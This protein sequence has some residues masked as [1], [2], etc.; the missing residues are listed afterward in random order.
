MKKK[1]VLLMLCVLIAGCSS[2]LDRVRK[3]NRER[4][5]KLST[6]LT[7]EEALKVMGK[8]AGGGLFG[9]PTVKSPYKSET[10]QSGGRN[11]EILY[12]YTDINSR[13]HISNPGTIRDKD[14]TP[15][16]FE[17]DILI[18]WGN[19]FLESLKEPVD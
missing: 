2:P 18:G 16:V 8:S 4:I 5:L 17:D 1:I 14:L 10:L 3:T 13:I 7:K 9:E 11:F 6:G 15:L 19:S 12:Y